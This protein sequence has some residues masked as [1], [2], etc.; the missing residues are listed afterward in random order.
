MASSEVAS[1]QAWKRSVTP[2]SGQESAKRARL[3]GSDVMS[4]SDALAGPSTAPNLANDEDVPMNDAG[5][6]RTHKKAR[7][8]KFKRPPPPEPGSSED[9]ILHDVMSLLGAEAVA[10]ATKNKSDYTS[11]LEKGQE[12]ELVVSELSSNGKL[13]L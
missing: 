6:S 10:A 7:P 8:K 5:S 12:I 1:T 11:P 4:V 2:P 13:S 3:E 9:V